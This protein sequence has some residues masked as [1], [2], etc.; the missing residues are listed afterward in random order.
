[1]ERALG[2]KLDKV[3]DT[4]EK[5]TPG[6]RKGLGLYINTVYG[7]R[8]NMAVLPPIKMLDV[9]KVLLSV[10]PQKAD[11]TVDDS[12]IVTWSSSDP[13]QVGV[14]PSSTDNGRSCFALTPLESGTA[15]ISASAP[16]YDT[17]TVEVSYAPGVAGKLNLSAGTPVSDAPTP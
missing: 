2:G 16:G 4:L 15:I 11:G 13:T 17:D 12:V 14:E 10:A 6:P 5:H 3:I 1:M 7:K 9:E 8:C